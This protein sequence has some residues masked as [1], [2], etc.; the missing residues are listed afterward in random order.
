MSCMSS[1]NLCRATAPLCSGRRAWARWLAA[2]VLT[3]I[4]GVHAEGALTL[5]T[6]TVPLDRLP[7]GCSISASPPVW[8]GGTVVSSSP[9]NGTDPT[10]LAAIRERVAGSPP[11]PDG[12]PLSRSESARF[13]LDLAKDVEE[14]YAAVYRDG[15]PVLIVVHAVRFVEKTAAGL[16]QGVTTSLSGTRIVVGNTAVVVSGKGRCFQAVASFITEKTAPS[17]PGALIVLPLTDRDASDPASCLFP[18]PSFLVLSRVLCPASFVLRP[19][20]LAP[21]SSLAL[22]SSLVPYLVPRPSFLTSSLV[23]RSCNLL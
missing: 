10:A 22:T 1:P 16:P 11:V 2:A 8:L 5:G 19:S 3:A 17:P 18:R 4:A 20:S 23:P 13:R 9:W 21:T 7:V 15:G 6:L 14:A 12:P